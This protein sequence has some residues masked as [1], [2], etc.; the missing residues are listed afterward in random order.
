MARYLGAQ[1]SARDV[2]V[3]PVAVIG[4]NFWGYAWQLYTAISQ[5]AYSPTRPVLILSRPATPQLMARLGA[6]SGVWVISYRGVSPT[7]VLPGCVPEAPVNF[8]PVAELYRVHIP[9]APAVLRF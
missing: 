5:Y 7:E 1:A 9:E 8:F 3:I 4:G 2:V 6:A